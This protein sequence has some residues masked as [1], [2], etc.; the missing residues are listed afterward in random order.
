MKYLTRFMPVLA[1]VLL[2]AGVAQAENEPIREPTPSDDFLIRAEMIPMRDGVKLHTVIVTSK[3]IASPQPILLMRT[4]YDAS[5]RIGTAHRT[6]MAAMLGAKYAELD[7]YIWVFQDIRGRYKSEGE[8]KAFRSMRGPFNDTQT[9]HTTDGWDTIDWLVKNVPHNN[10]RVGLFG[11]S[12]EGWLILTSLLDPH[13]A[14]EATVPVNPMVDIWMGDDAFHNGAFRVGFMLEYLYRMEMRPGKQLVLPHDHYDMYDWWLRQ[15]SARTVQAQLL[16]KA[17]FFAQLIERP[18]YDAF[19]EDAAIDRRLAKSN[20][21]LVPTLHVH[22]WFDQEDIYGAPAAYAALEPRDSGDDLNYFTAGPW[23]HGGNWAGGGHM[24]ALD[25]TEAT[26]RRWRQDVLAPFL[27]HYLKGAPAHG[28][29]DA[30][31]FNTGTGR[32]ESFSSWPKV[33]AAE[34]RRLY[35]QSGKSL[36]WSAPQGTAKESA[37]RYVSD[38]A[39]PI[40]Y[41]PRPIKSYYGD[42]TNRD[43]WR[44]WHVIDQR[45]VDGRPDVLTYVSEPLAEPV[46]V[47]GDVTAHLFAATTGSDADWVV[48]LIDVFPDQDAFEPEMSGY[49]F[50]VSGEILRGRYRESFS[51]PKAIAANRVLEYGIRM[52]QVNHTFRRGHRLMV[53]VQSSWFPLYDRNPQTFVPSIMDA[54]PAD[55]RA[56]THSIHRGGKQA[57]H[58]ELQVAR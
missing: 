15:G 1:G 58:I 12:Y 30:T 10:G 54:K 37:D 41:Q 55:Y 51:E 16:P 28:L 44:I 25:W 8:Y 35:L 47:R 17:P 21:P 56:A 42:D 18:S 38:P 22:S 45:F 24:G 27:A 57:S 52:P 43:D 26:G 34:T 20:A 13:P 7:G 53:Q 14:L 46:T 32:W 3:S 40:P 6:S 11:T 33:P 9:D 4:P 5:G 50:M 19:W 2:L 36:S 48:K 31:V 49:Q 29:S 39:S 23:Y